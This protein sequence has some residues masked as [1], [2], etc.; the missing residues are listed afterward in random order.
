MIRKP[1]H[2]GHL[3]QQVNAVHGTDV[4]VLKFELFWP[5]FSRTSC[6]STG[7]VCFQI[8]VLGMS[9]VALEELCGPE[10]EEYLDFQI[11]R[12][13]DAH[14]QG[15]SWIKFYKQ[16]NFL[17]SSR[18][19]A[20]FSICNYNYIK[21]I[22][23]HP[24]KLLHPHHFGNDLDFSTSIINHLCQDESGGLQRHILGDATRCHWP[25]EELANIEKARW[26]SLFK[27]KLILYLY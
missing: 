20:F 14:R 4:N 25:G 13:G 16:C 2:C 3:P 8:A 27:N 6:I 12:V 21:M 1:W 5:N 11:S 19:Q 7:S 22:N 10:V 9:N 23:I 26:R 18:P 17:M 15:W 24:W